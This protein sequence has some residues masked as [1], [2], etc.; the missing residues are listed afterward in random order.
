MPLVATALSLLAAACGTGAGDVTAPPIITSPTGV[1][2]A[3]DDAGLAA[4]PG[5]ASEPDGGP[6]GDLDDDD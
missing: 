1:D 5:A 2:Q 4:G 6:V 3:A